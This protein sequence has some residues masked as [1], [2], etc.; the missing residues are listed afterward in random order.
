MS[1]RPLNRDKVLVR[2]RRERFTL[3]KDR[4]PDDARVRQNWLVQHALEQADQVGVM[5]DG[6]KVRQL[7]HGVILLHVLRLRLDAKAVQVGDRVGQRRVAFNPTG[8]AGDLKDLPAQRF[9]VGGGQQIANEQIAVPFHTPVQ[10][11]SIVH[12]IG[13]IN[14][15]LHWIL[16]FGVPSEGMPTE[17]LAPGARLN[18]VSAPGVKRI[19]RVGQRQ[20]HACARHMR[21]VRSHGPFDMA[22]GGASIEQRELRLAAVEHRQHRAGHPLMRLHPLERIGRRV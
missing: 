11:C 14:K 8:V 9:D 22:A 13:R 21:G 15:R 19:M 6:V 16:S 1:G 5:L 7:V 2:R 18:R 20:R 4:A 12:N 17:Q 3:R 10:F